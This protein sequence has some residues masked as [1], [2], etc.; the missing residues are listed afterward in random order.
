MSLE[1][2]T[3]RSDGD[4]NKNLYGKELNAKQIV[5]GNVVQTPPAGQPFVDTLTKKSPK[6]LS[7]NK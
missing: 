1:G 4:A 7:E 5:T 3:L 6:N 2:S